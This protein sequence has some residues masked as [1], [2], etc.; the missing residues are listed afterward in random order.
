[1]NGKDER[2]DKSHAQRGL[3]L[4]SNQAEENASDAQKECRIGSCEEFEGQAS[5]KNY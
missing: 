3:E 1:M 4:T 2:L 5:T